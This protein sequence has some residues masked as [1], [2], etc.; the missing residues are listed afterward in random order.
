MSKSR[1][2]LAHL[3]YE[4]N[5]TKKGHYTLVRNGREIAAGHA[6]EGDIT[7]VEE[8]SDLCAAWVVYKTHG[9]NTLQALCDY[10]NDSAVWPSD[11]A[12]IIAANGWHDLTMQCYT[13]A[14]EGD[15][16]AM[17]DTHLHAY[18]AKLPY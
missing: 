1:D 16:I 14:A 18:V 11:V 7:S 5:E 10:I 17:Q 9:I 6:E 13:I 2:Y 8:Y 4:V 15:Y 12:D 3:G